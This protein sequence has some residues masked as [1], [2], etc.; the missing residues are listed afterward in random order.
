MNSPSW[1]RG[2]KQDMLDL[3]HRWE[4]RVLHSGCSS[5]RCNHFS[6]QVASL[7]SAYGTGARTAVMQSLSRNTSVVSTRILCSSHKWCSSKGCISKQWVSYEKATW[8]FSLLCFCWDRG[9]DRATAPSCDHSLAMWGR[10]HLEPRLEIPPQGPFG[11]LGPRLALNMPF[12][13]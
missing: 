11:H 3:G 7:T 6:L 4:Y 12:C 1:L 13:G 9:N 5:C 8:S 2:S 10:G